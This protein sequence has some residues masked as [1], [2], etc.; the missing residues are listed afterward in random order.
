MQE[1]T[2]QLGSAHPDALAMEAAGLAWLAE[3]E[4]RGGTRIARVL[5]RSRSSLTL[6][7]IRSSPSTNDR[8]ELFGR[9]LAR[10]HSLGA[11]WHACPPE[12][13]TGN[14][15]VGTS[16]T[17]LSPAPVEGGWGMSFAQVLIEPILERLF[18]RGDMDDAALRLFSSVCSRLRDGVFDAPQPEGV[19]DVARIHGD[20]W[21]GNV[22]WSDV[23]TGAVLIDPH[24]QGGHAETDLAMLD[25]FGLAHLDRVIG[26]YDEV[27]PLAG[28]WQERVELQQLQPLLVHAWL[29]GG[30]YLHRALEA[31]RR[32]A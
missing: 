30:G 7:Y 23:E 18:S 14:M 13:Y 20:L 19:P 25:L 5:R 32:F 3:A 22:L 27:A 8:A 6:E 28:Q 21:A 1:F 12:G 24:A 16:E 17:P 9:S 26:A 10:L 4:P 11:P 31:A 29:F 2:K 15:V